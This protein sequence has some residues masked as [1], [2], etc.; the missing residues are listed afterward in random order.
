MIEHKDY[1][2]GLD[3]KLLHLDRLFFQL[4]FA[5]FG[6]CATNSMTLNCNFLFVKDLE[7]PSKE[8]YTCE[9]INFTNRVQNVQINYVTNLHEMGRRDRDVKVFIIKQQICHFLPL[10]IE[11]FFPNLQELEVDSSGL[12]K[13]YRENFEPLEN[14]RMAIF[15]GNDIEFLPGD[16][17][18]FNHRLTHIDFSQNK[19]KSIGRDIFDTLYNLKYLMFDDNHCFQGFGIV[20]DDFQT[21][22]DEVLKNCS[23]IGVKPEKRIVTKVVEVKKYEEKKTDG[24]KNEST[25]KKQQEQETRKDVAKHVKSCCNSKEISLEIIMICLHLHIFAALFR[26]RKIKF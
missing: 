21:V 3:L 13:L 15:P 14:L 10:K 9:S 12:K 6:I 18:A 1:E 2:N 16:L 19:I 23:N 4:Y 7:A 5:I 26:E 17:F 25:E 20:L 11:N 8:I 22:K 24:I